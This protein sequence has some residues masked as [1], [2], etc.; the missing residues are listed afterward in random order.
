MIKE[1]LE[2][3]SI[4]GV[5]A[6]KSEGKT[7]TVLTELLHIK[8]EYPQTSIYVY[9]I[10]GELHKTLEENGINILRNKLD[11]LDLKI[12]NSIIFVDEIALF[13]DSK[14]SSKQGQKFMRFCDRIEHKNDKLIMATAREGYF[15]KFMC[16]RVTC[17]IVKQIEYDALVNGTWL[18]ESVKGI[19]SVSDYRLNCSKDTYYIVSNKDGLTQSVNVPYYAPLDTKKDNKCIF[20]EK[21]KTTKSKQTPLEQKGFIKVV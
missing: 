13:F 3:H 21:K 17:F 6:N 2:K 20:G 9:G 8:K 10:N 16:G 19:E 14:G 5:A 12:S 4:V 7:M 11:V 18:K 15:N 1:L